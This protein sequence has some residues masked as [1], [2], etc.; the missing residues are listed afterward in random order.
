MAMASAIIRNLLETIVGAELGATEGASV[1]G[2][3]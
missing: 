3:L 1:E 2:E